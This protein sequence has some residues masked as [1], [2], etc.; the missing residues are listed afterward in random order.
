LKPSFS[1][2]H[3][4]SQLLAD[5]SKYNWFFKYKIYHLP[6]WFAYHCAWWTLLTGSVQDVAHNILYS[7]YGIKFSFYVIFQ[8]VAVYFNLYFL[9]PRYFE[10]GKYV[11]Y[12]LSL[13][14]TVVLAALT[15][16]FGY[17]VNA[18]VYHTT[19]QELFG[20][21]TT[22][23]LYFFKANTMPSTAAATTLGMS[24]KLAKNWV[25]DRRRQQELEKEKLEAE[26]KF[27]KSQF[28]PHFLFNT[29]NSIFVLIKKNP[30]MASESL[31]KFS[32]LLR[33]QLYECNEH[34]IP[35]KQELAY[36]DNFVELAKLRL[37]QG[38]V[39]VQ[40]D[41]ERDLPKEATIA[42]FVLMPFVEN[43]FKHV[44]QRKTK[45]NWI[46]AELGIMNN[47]LTFRIV[48]SSDAPQRSANEA[49]SYGGIGLKNVRRRLELIYPG[50]Y[51]LSTESHDGEFK[52]KLTIGLDREPARVPEQV[53]FLERQRLSTVLSVR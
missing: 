7:P 12:F 42:P 16:N 48:N 13:A 51:E 44:S 53:S 39:N 32:E 19:V 14:G 21:S 45:A 28:N 10:R 37:D 18:W 23:S 30:D 17:F 4:P 27:L 43:A 1:I 36:L 46:R 47:K 20:I 8:A 5:Q 25:R 40:F 41:V 34:K 50:Q 52:V 3:I 9:M 33:Y 38:R 26:L 35:M 22:D 6:F 24:V 2:F 29:I 49:V 31:A 11:V 15:I